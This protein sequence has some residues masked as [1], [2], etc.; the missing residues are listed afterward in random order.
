MTSEIRAY[1]PGW[2]VEKLYENSDYKFSLRYFQILFE[3]ETKPYRSEEYYHYSLIIR[4]PEGTNAVDLFDEAVYQLKNQHLYKELE[5]KTVMKTVNKQ[6]Y[7]QRINVT[8]E[9]CSNAIQVSWNLGK[10]R[11]T[12]EVDADIYPKVRD[13]LFQ[14]FTELAFARI[15]VTEG[16]TSNT[17]KGTTK[18]TVTNK[19]Y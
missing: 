14:E 9:Q 19:N 2:I 1:L 10:P 12:L 3:D 18:F 4:H 15:G 11:V 7:E 16:W 5:T 13:R 17:K 6:A 8:V